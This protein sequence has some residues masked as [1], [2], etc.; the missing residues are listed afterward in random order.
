MQNTHTPATMDPARE[1]ADSEA[2]ITA[3]F[4]WAYALGPDGVPDEVKRR[5]VL[6]LFD[7]LAAMVGA[8]AEP[9]FQRALPTLS[10]AACMGGTPEATLIPLPGVRTDCRSAALINAV[11]TNWLELDEGYRTTP[12]HAGLYLLPAL[13]ADAEATGASVD[14]VLCSIAVGYEIVT[15]IARAYA[16]RPM[17][18][19]SHGRYGAVGAAAAVALNRK[20]SA[21]GALEAVSAAVTL[22][23]PSPRNHLALGA[24][25]RNVW[26]GMGAQAGMMAVDLAAGGITGTPGSF[27]DVYCTVLHGIYRGEFLTQ[28]LGQSWAILDGYTKMY[29]CCQHLHAA[30]EAVLQIRG[31]ALDKGFEQLATIEVETHEL[32]LPLDN[33]HPRTSLA[34]KFSMSHAVAAA[35]VNGNGGAQAFASTTL[36]DPQV[37]RLRE[38]VSMIRW[39]GE[40]PEAPNDRPT[41][42][43]LD[44]KDGTRLEA[45]TLSARGGPDRPY[46]ESERLDKIAGLSRAMYPG[47][48]PMADTLLA[49]PAQRLRQPWREVI[50]EFT[51]T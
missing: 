43:Y 22:I 44:F 14:E 8:A 47:L 17:V 34:A 31:E 39:P 21:H 46:D 1:R 10:G 45:L 4:D 13:L 48:R 6:V 35:L 3:L 41:R 25:V 27:H 32:A 12:C 38:R 33:P 26:A 11:A 37:S 36:A 23:G 42:V 15:R 50:A 19:Q 5:A 28:E 24:L 51:R 7:D 20:L 49:L 9:E 40:L 16:Q 29:A 18:M 30:V 2:R